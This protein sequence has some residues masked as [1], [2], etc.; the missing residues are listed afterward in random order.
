MKKYH[1][2]IIV[3]ICGAAIMI[4]ELIGSRVLAPYVGTS[5][6][7]WSNLI[8][9]ILGSLSLGYWLGGKLADKYSDA[10]FLSIIILSAGFLILFSTIIK[11]ILLYS[12]HKPIPNISHRA[13][14]RYTFI[15]RSTKHFLGMVTPYA[16]KLRL[17]SIDSSGK[18]VGNLYA[19]STIGS[20]VGTFLT[21]FVLIPFMGSTKILLCLSIILLCC[22]MSFHSFKFKKITCLILFLLIMGISFVKINNIVLT[23]GKKIVDIETLYNRVWI[24]NTL[25]D[26][27]EKIKVMRINNESNSARY[28]YKK[29]LVYDYLKFFHLAK[30]F[31]PNIRKTLMIG[32][33][34]YTYP[35]DYIAKNPYAR[36]DV[37]E[38]DPDIWIKMFSKMKEF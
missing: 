37:V 5:I 22:A 25:N 21:G 17:N 38:I 23:K 35:T 7:V 28:M 1:L 6:F 27:R 33:A 4:L 26:K 10:K 9:I 16:V 32:G 31:N 12:L 30:H 2:E 36:I 19:I 11:D 3:F 24:Y 13:F 34:G 15:I 20:I 18:T 8:G 29:D 14:V